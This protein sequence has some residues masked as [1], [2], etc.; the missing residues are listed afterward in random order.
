MENEL[1][2]E[3]IIIFIDLRARH[4][5]VTHAYKTFIFQQHTQRLM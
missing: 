4:K 3:L 1:L 2:A 5:N